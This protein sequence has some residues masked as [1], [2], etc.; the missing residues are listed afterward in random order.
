MQ[1]EDFQRNFSPRQNGR[2]YL[3]YEIRR[4]RRAIQRNWCSNN[5]EHAEI[6]FL[7]NHFNSRPRTPCSI[8]WFISSSP[9]GNCCRRILEFLRSHPNVTLDIYA[10]KLFRRFDIRNR[11]GLRS[12]MMNG[13]TIRI[14]NLEDYRYCWRNFVA[15]QPGEDDYWPQNVTLY[16]ILNSIELLHIFL[17][18]AMDF[19]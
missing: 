11:R 17:D 14:M 7:E 1:P 3:L 19:S 18:R 5:H 13:V 15:H 4:R 10:A 2:V 16:F 6:N 12:L 8:T 9:C